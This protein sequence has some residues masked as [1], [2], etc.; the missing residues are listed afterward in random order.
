MGAGCHEMR[1]DVTG[2][3]TWL[4]QSRCVELTVA[5][6]LIFA[7]ESACGSVSTYGWQGARTRAG[8]AGAAGAPSLPA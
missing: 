4:P 1:V 6:A 2:T 3:G 8:P 5:A 7:P